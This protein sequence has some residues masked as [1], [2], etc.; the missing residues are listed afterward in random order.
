MC[1]TLGIM[2]MPRQPGRP[3]GMSAGSGR[4]YGQGP[5]SVPSDWQA[6]FIEIEDHML[7]AEVELREVRQQQQSVQ[8]G[9]EPQ[10]LC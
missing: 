6:R 10:P 2:I 8:L 1:V 3:R 4:D 7:H 9:V 5:L